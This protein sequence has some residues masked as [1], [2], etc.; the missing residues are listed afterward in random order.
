MQSII[1]NSVMEPKVLLIIFSTLLGVV[2][3]VGFILFIVT[4]K[5]LKHKMNFYIKGS[6]R[7]LIYVVNLKTEEVIYFNR[8]K[9]DNKIKTTLSR[10]LDLYHAKD[11]RKILDWFKSI[12]ENPD[13]ASRFIDV[14]TRPIEKKTKVALFSLQNYDKEERIIYFSAK[15]LINLSNSVDQKKDNDTKKYFNSTKA[16]MERYYNF[17][18]NPHGYVYSIHFFVKNIEIFNEIPSDIDFDIKNAIFGY[19]KGK[20]YYRYFLKEKDN[21]I[22][23]F[24]FK[25][26]NQEKALDFSN[27]LSKTLGACLITNG[28]SDVCGYSIG[29]ASISDFKK[30]FKGVIDAAN[31]ACEI[32]KTYS[33]FYYFY[34]V[35]KTINF[36]GA[37]NKQNA[38]ELFNNT[39]KKYTFRPIIGTN[40][41]NVYGYFSF[42]KTNDD[43]FTNYQQMVRAAYKV[44]KNERL[45]K[46]VATSIIQKFAGY[47]KTS[48]SK[49]F[50]SVSLLDLGYIDKVLSEIKEAEDLNIVLLFEENEMNANSISQDLV[51]KELKNLSES[52]FELA[53]LMKDENM[54]LKPDIYSIFNSFVLGSALVSKVRVSN[55]IKLSNRFLI[56]QLMQFKRPIIATDLDGWPSVELFVKSGIKYLSCNDIAPTSDIITPVDKRKLAKIETYLKND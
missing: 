27:N 25:Q 28:Y 24:D 26:T 6:S 32:A 52:G 1:N 41:L 44:D 9:I 21:R 31:E 43:K 12:E 11:S 48:N 46:D 19:V 56:E 53:L 42:A 22:L 37:F 13:T 18:R 35:E 33:N 36:D 39:S 55:R 7:F 40:K 4:R 54:L 8:R 34:E 3:L 15:I 17:Q 49:L 14:E 10:F 2:L 50:L 30:N 45:F 23:I 29:V 16:A 47:K 51:T 20:N 5:K 38:E